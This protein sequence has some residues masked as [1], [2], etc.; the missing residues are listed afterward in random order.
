[1]AIEEHFHDVQ[2]GWHAGQQQACNP[3][4]NIACWNLCGWQHTQVELD[5]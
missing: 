2:D 4:S 3:W 5:G 1:V